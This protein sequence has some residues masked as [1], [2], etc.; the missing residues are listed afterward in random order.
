MNINKINNK[1]SK[2]LLLVLFIILST[3]SLYKVNAETRNYTFQ[4]LKSDPE[5]YCSE[6]GA[7]LANSNPE[8]KI[9]GGELQTTF[10]YDSIGTTWTR[11]GKPTFNGWNGD[12]YRIR[13]N[14]PYTKIGESFTTAAEAWVLINGSGYSSPWQT[15]WWK[16]QAGKGYLHTENGDEEGNQ[17]YL[18]YNVDTNIFNADNR[19]IASAGTSLLDNLKKANNDRN[20]YVE[21]A[22]KITN[23]AAKDKPND[24][25][26]EEDIVP[27][28]LTPPEASY[29]N[30]SDK[31]AEIPNDIAA[32][33]QG[34]TEYIEAMTGKK[35]AVCNEDGF[36]FTR[37]FDWVNKDVE[38]NGKKIPYSNPTI[39]KDGNKFIVG[40]FAIDYVDM[41]KYS[42][43]YN[44]KMEMRKD[45][46]TT[47]VL[48]YNTSKQEFEI[49]TESKSFF[50]DPNET[51]YLVFDSIQNATSIK[52]ISVG[53]KYMNATAKYSLW[54]ASMTTS[55]GEIEGSDKS[56]TDANGNYIERYYLRR[57]EKTYSQNAQTLAHKEEQCKNWYVELELMRGIDLVESNINV[58]KKIITE[59]EDGK[60]IDYSTLSKDSE[61]RNFY[62]KLK[63]K[64]A[65]TGE[66][67]D[68]E[69]TL[70]VTA[71]NSFA[72]QS[73]VYYWLKNDENIAPT[74]ELTEV[75][76]EGYEL[77]DIKEIKTNGHGTFA[78]GKFTGTLTSDTSLNLEATNIIKPHR[79]NI[80]IIKEIDEN[81]DENGK[82]YIVQKGPYNVKVTITPPSKGFFKYDGKYYGNKESDK[83]L[84]VN[85][86]VQANNSVVLPHEIEWYGEAAPTFKVTEELKPEQSGIEC[87]KI[88]PEQGALVDLSNTEDNTVKVTIT[89]T[90]TDHKASLHIIK[91]VEI[92]NAFEGIVSDDQKEILKNKLIEKIRNQKFEFDITVEGND[93]EHII[94]EKAKLE[95]NKL[96]WEGFSSEYKWQGDANNGPS[97]KI[98]E[99][100]APKGT[101]C[102]PNPAEGQL[103]ENAENN[104]LV[105][106]QITN[107]I[108][109]IEHKAKLSLIKKVDTK[110]LQDKEYAFDVRLVSG[111][112]TYKGEIFE[113]SEENPLRIT[114]KDENDR[115][116]T[117]DDE[118]VK[119][120]VGSSDEDEASNKWEMENFIT[121]FEYGTELV[122]KPK[123]KVNEVKKLF[124]AEVKTTEIQP[125]EGY[126]HD[127]YN[128]ET[129]EYTSDVVVITAI[130]HGEKTHEGKIHLIKTLEDADKY[131]KEILSQIKFEFKVSIDRNANDNW[132]DE[133]DENYNIVLEPKF[134]EN[135]TE[136]IWEWETNPAIA[137]KGDTA[138]KY[139][140]EEI[141]I[142]AGFSF[143][144]FK[145]E[146][147]DIHNDEHYI[148]GTLKEL[149]EDN[150]EFEVNEVNA[151]NKIDEHQGK[152]A[153][154]KLVES[155]SLKGKEF[156]FTVTVE[157]TF[158][159]GD[160]ENTAKE[161]KNEKFTFDVKVKEGTTWESELF[162]WGAISTP[163]YTVE[164][165]ED[166]TYKCISMINNTGNLVNNSTVTATFKNKSTETKSAYL[167]VTKIL[168]AGQTTDKKFKFDVTIDGK[169][170][171]VELKPGETY[172]SN[173]YTWDVNGQAP[174]YTVRE[175]SDDE[176]V[177]K[178][179]IEITDGHTG[180]INSDGKGGEISGELKP[181]TTVEVRATNSVNEKH[182]KFKVIKQI[183]ADEKYVKGVKDKEFNITATVT[184]N[185]LVG[186]E[187]TP[188][189]GSKDF[190]FSLKADEA[191]NSP[192][193]Y[194]TGN[195]AP[196]VTVKED[197]TGEEYKG[198][199]NTGISNNGVAISKDFDV[200]I[201][202]TNEYNII[203][204]L[205]LTVEL[206]GD[207][208]EDVGQDEK[209]KEAEPNGRIDGNETGID[210]VEVYVYKAGTNELA[211][212]YKDGL[213]AIQPQP[214][215]TSNNGHWD[216]YRV[217]IS[218]EIDSFEVRF[219]YDGQTYENTK[220]LALSDEN[221]KLLADKVSDEKRKN[222]YN[223]YEK[224]L[225]ARKIEL[226]KS[227]ISKTNRNYY[228]KTS[229][230]VDIDRQQVDSRIGEIYGDKSIDSLGNTTGKVR[231]S[232][233][234]NNIYYTSNVTDL[235][236]QTRVVSNVKT[237]DND[238]V[239]LDLFKATASTGDLVFPFG[240]N[241]EDRFHLTGSE[242]KITDYGTEIVY[243]YSATYDYTKHI[244]L[245]LKRRPE[246][247]V[248]IQKDLVSAKVVVNDRLANYT[249]NK[250]SDIGKELKCMKL[251]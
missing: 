188:V 141:N 18:A 95:D 74:F 30:P 41:G 211:T 127:I 176:S 17:D 153:I 223:N 146:D 120:T 168:E 167:K 236:D 59:D 125:N 77:K 175:Y 43:M 216:A 185:F 20:S 202:V 128:E 207:V 22:G 158:K 224:L 196:T 85:V 24:P 183:I 165:K 7:P 34:F 206:A 33:V 88:Y 11:V 218:D 91:T 190:K 49:R 222:D 50:P 31:P 28:P 97:Y 135:D 162:R 55:E 66:E 154:K 240:T 3:T 93:T 84:V 52:N 15:A 244:N 87:K 51:F 170:T 156:E 191:W 58:I 160:D 189:N 230:A 178:E 145:A 26:D 76:K 241:F 89:N 5:L 101:T 201:V 56:F 132:E 181:G 111:L 172:T 9:N 122:E 209:S 177:L 231:K 203:P 245:G 110:D 53:I 213:D 109:V 83:E 229:M 116:A 102:I 63:V 45:D 119:I 80:K 32:E 81:V 67:N 234:V 161:F 105:D 169:T 10:P 205:D 250:L 8:Y 79:G 225:D 247:D 123:Y 54:D 171:T 151:V 61:K 182:G 152:L 19:A 179:I 40:P 78:D 243:H 164:E 227:I 72:T 187:K 208:W 163:K 228:S 199:E 217:N 249:F 29:E 246:A 138:P 173:S 124:L 166:S 142:P 210:G 194:W 113:P 92:E 107:K 133:E 86:E 46:G 198:W 70:V 2:V 71:G 192:I 219:V 62:F 239:A 121:W 112:F 103:V 57:S 37:V 148:I 137:W 226:Y 220:L 144:E 130:N 150:I 115:K 129:D 139:K 108:K 21:I 180:T 6:H 90:S 99:V 143:K 65:L 94:I 134:V 126:L 193:I 215:I 82:N 75:S 251:I 237:T 14:S 48:E 117:S 25:Q 214:I 44:M 4:I 38:K 27:D 184:G 174:K 155:S 73:R 147:A 42:Y 131:G 212:I 23:F 195:N 100:N 200:E 140:I 68:E 159:Y 136:C 233:E 204:R 221:S 12:T 248:E 60:E 232:D 1:I 69:E 47:K 235:G 149:E 36:K 39:A 35:N 242:T 106:N 114:N 186:D 16:T 98:E 197:L 104:Y 238:G 118:Y 13:N 157:G 96:I 64:G